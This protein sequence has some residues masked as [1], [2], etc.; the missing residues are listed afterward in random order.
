[1]CART[2]APVC[3][4]VCVCVYLCVC[5]CAPVH[6]IVQQ[7][8]LVKLLLVQHFGLNKLF[9]QMLAPF[10]DLPHSLAQLNRRRGRRLRKSITRERGKGEDRREWEHGERERWKGEEGWKGL[11]IGLDMITKQL[12]CRTYTN[13]HHNTHSS[14]VYMILYTISVQLHCT[15]L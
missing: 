15:H 3:V 8:P 12:A 5:V 10:A 13:Y 4:C 7:F 11:G 14:T 6:F 1:M 9:L 2:S